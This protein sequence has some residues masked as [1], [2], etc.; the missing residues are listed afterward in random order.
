MWSLP[1]ICVHIY[2]L[3]RKLLESC[4]CPVLRQAHNEQNQLENSVLMTGLCSVGS[5]LMS[6]PKVYQGLLKKT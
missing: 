3:S 5:G 1:K 4:L 6:L 2:V